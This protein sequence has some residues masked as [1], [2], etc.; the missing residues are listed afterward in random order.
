MLRD[1]GAQCAVGRARVDGYLGYQISAVYECIIYCVRCV[2]AYG[3]L[4]VLA[5]MIHSVCGIC[6]CAAVLRFFLG[7]LVSVRAHMCAFVLFVVASTTST[8]TSS[9]RY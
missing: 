9:V 1:A 2:A 4:C 7:T 6:T 5:C 8:S 3:G